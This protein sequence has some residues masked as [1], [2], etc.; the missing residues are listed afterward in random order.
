M[1]TNSDRIPLRTVPDLRGTAAEDASGLSVGTLWGALSEADTGL[2]RYL[3]LQLQRQARHVLVPIGH[4]RLRE[5]EGVATVRLRAA[6]LE[7]LESIPALPA[8][9]D[10]FDDG[11][12]HGLL[13]AHGRAFHGERYY[14]HPSFDH[15]GL[16]AGEHPIVR[17]G[18][19][20]PAESLTPLSEL[21][22]YRVARGE[23]DIRGW[24]LRGAGGIELGTIRDLV[25]DR[26]SEKVR[27]ASLAAA[28]GGRQVLV[29]VGYLGIDG[30]AER[31]DAPALAEADVLALPGYAGGPVERTDEEAVLAVLREQLRG[32]RRYLGP[33]FNPGALDPSRPRHG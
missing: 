27:Y 30:E 21:P 32:G 20:E 16:Y 9:P 10:G 31:V 5:T 7:D 1:N 23:P 12:E 14:A 25:V 6:L 4:A 15:S 22:A 26:T 19:V 24:P 33:D 18:S 2:L 11:F 8:D 3:D 28:P 13:E 17:A 29:P